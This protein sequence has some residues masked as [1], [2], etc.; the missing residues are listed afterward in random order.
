[1]ET[2]FRWREAVADLNAIQG[3][4]RSRRLSR[5]NLELVEV[6]EP[7]FQ[8]QSGA[9]VELQ[10]EINHPN[11][12]IVLRFVNAR[13]GAQLANFLGRY[14]FP[15]RG[16]FPLSNEP[17]GVREEWVRSDQTA[18]AELLSKA[19]GGDPIELAPQINAAL[20]A[21]EIIY[22]APMMF[23]PIPN[24][25]APPR[26]PKFD[27]LRLLPTIDYEPGASVPRFVFRSHSLYDHMVMECATVAVAG[28]I[29]R[30]CDHCGNF[31]LAG[32]S[33]GRRA[34]GRFCS[35]RCR[36]AAMRKRK[37]DELSA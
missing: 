31:Y 27:P 17:V 12:F 19:G 15:R 34:A 9:S 18:L 22:Q 23:A 33:T 4:R 13:T 36:V 14:G 28:I 2:V 3:A 16:N 24:P 29:A 25:P 10:L 20:A 21:D 6:P 37:A 32:G 11:D 26:P 30:P 5:E 8:E 35:D 1:M 7:E